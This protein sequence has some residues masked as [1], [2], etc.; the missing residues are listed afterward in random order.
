MINAIKQKLSHLLRLNNKRTMK[1]VHLHFD[2]PDSHPY[3]RPDWYFQAYGNIILPIVTNHLPKRFWFSQY[4][5]PK[6]LLL[7]YESQ[8]IFDDLTNLSI[9]PSE[10]EEFDIYADL[11]QPRHFGTNQRMNDKNDRGSKIFDFLHAASV[12]TLDQLSHQE[13]GYWVW[14]ENSDRGNNHYGKTLEIV[15]HLF[16]NLSAVPTA[17]VE[18]DPVVANQKQLHP[19][20]SPLYA[21]IHG[22]YI[23]TNPIISIQY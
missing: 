15:H 14:E 9:L 7:R 20:Q 19:L 16:C 13:N 11:S 22:G 6:H 4:Q 3:D 23:Q 12:L 17:V 21:K 18:I 1:Q 2:I 8:E 10:H 5:P